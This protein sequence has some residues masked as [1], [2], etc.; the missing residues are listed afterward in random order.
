MK[1]SLKTRI[2]SAASFKDA[3]ALLEEGAQYL[4]ASKATRRQWQREAAKHN[5]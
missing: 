2:K 4:Y 5:K 3:K 1:I